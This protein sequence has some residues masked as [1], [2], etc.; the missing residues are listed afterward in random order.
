MNIQKLHTALDRQAEQLYE[1]DLEKSNKYDGYTRP[2]D[3]L[4]SLD[5]LELTDIDEFHEA[6]N[7]LEEKMTDE[8]IES[9]FERIVKRWKK[10][11]E[12][13]HVSDG[14]FDAMEYNKNPHA[15]YGVSKS[16]FL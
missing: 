9:L 12:L 10:Q 14:Y 4:D 2:D 5:E 1:L 13:S 3:F 16:D 15:Y 8:E 7:E 6:Y 11:A